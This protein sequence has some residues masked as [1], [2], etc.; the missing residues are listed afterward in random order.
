MDGRVGSC[1]SEHI[2]L[3]P[4]QI[5]RD[6]WHG[7]AARPVARSLGLSL[8]WPKHGHPLA[9]RRHDHTRPSSRTSDSVADALMQLLYRP[10]TRNLFS[11]EL[12]AEVSGARL[13]V[14]RPLFP[15]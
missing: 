12:Q 14:A 3:P 2:R 4:S 13:M 6:D 9:P 7:Q 15:S 5:T 1:P 10:A 11:W 8:F